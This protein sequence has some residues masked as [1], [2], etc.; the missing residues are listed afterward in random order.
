VT[1]K[2]YTTF[3]ANQNCKKTTYMVECFEMILYIFFV[4]MVST[5]PS[6]SKQAAPMVGNV[7]LMLETGID[8]SQ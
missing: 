3:K 1:Y 6:S 5:S 4:Y 7:T 2:I 8:Y